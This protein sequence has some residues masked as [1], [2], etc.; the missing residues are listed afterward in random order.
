MIGRS[1]G[2]NAG[3]VLGMDEG[4]REHGA[5]PLWLG[6]ISV[7]DV[8]A[9]IGQIGAKGGT[10][11]MPATDIQGVGRIAMVADPQGAAFMMMTPDGPTRSETPPH[12]PGH[13]GWRE[14]HTTDWEAAV[15][16][17]SGEFGWARSDAMDM[18]EMGTYQII[19]ENGVQIGAMYNSP[20][21]PRPMWLFYFSV[22]SIDAAVEKVKA[23]GGQVINGPMAVPGDAWI[24]NATDPQGAMFALVG[25]K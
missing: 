15:G 5:K 18:G 3:G 17:Y 16:F 25:G 4:M 8:D 7:D 12:T 2:G 21:V 1:D 20:D 24:I 13:I 6:Y 23:G 22:P 14:L 11:H 10:V 9:S 19:A